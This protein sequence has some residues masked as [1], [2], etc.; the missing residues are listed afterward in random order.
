MRT[1]WTD[2]MV[3]VELSKVCSGIGRMVTNTE[4]RELGRNDL[5]CQIVKRGGYESFTK[6][7][8]YD[9]V[10][11][12]SHFWWQG[13]KAVSEKL[14][15]LGYTVERMPEKRAPFDMIVNGLVRVD[16]KTANY[17][18]YGYSIGWFYRI[19]K[20]CP[21][22]VVILHQFDTGDMYLIPWNKCQTS[23]ITITKTGKTYEE[24]R[25]NYGIIDK[26]VDAFPWKS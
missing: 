16:V 19:D 6:R 7:L 11:S 12:D 20:I 24:Y 23:N 13:E 10:A 18:N 25:N 1:K 9:M 14:T 2:D 8:G 4:L 15:S 22:D 26:L 5:A 21:A 3:L 17:A